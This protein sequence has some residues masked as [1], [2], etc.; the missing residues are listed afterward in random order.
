MAAFAVASLLAFGLLFVSDEGRD[1]AVLTLQ[2][3]K[4]VLRSGFMNESGGGYQLLRIR[5]FTFSSNGGNCASDKLFFG[6]PVLVVFLFSLRIRFI[7]VDS[8]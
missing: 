5:F 7:S 8:L 3:V 4:V 2:R 1:F 6:G